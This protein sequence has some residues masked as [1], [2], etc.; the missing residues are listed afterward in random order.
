MD[1]ADKELV[2]EF[3]VESQEGLANVEA[4]ML[5]IEAQGAN[6]DTD[7]VNSVFRTM[8]SIKGAAGF[9]GL[10]RI[11]TL[12]HGLEE[13]L[14]NLRNREMIPTTE[15]ISTILRA[16]DFMKGLIDEVE[17]SNEADVAPFVAELQ[18]FRPG[19]VAVPE[20]PVVPIST[21][22]T[23][24]RKV[25]S[26]G[27]PVVSPTAPDASVPTR[28]SV[29]EEGDPS[30]ALSSAAINVPLSDTV[31]EFLIECD[32][33]LDQM[34][35]DLMQLEQDP[36]A[37]QL[38]R[39]IFRT[40]H[41]IKGGA[42]FLGL[43]E[44]EHLAHVAEDLLGKVRSG[45]RTFNRTICNAL[46]ATSDKCREGLAMVEST[47]NTS[48]LSPD[49]VIEML[50]QA[51]QA[52][53]ETVATPSSDTVEAPSAPV[54]GAAPET[55]A[56]APV[57]SHKPGA[58]AAQP[59]KPV[60]AAETPGATSA[61]TTNSGDRSNVPAGESTI[62]VDVE[63]LDKLM[64]R[65]GELVLARNQILQYTS[66]QKD[67]NFASTA[68]RLNLIT[69]ELQESVMKTRMQPIGNVWSKFPRVVRDLSAQL[70]KQV[71]IEMEGKETELDKTIIE[72]IKD[73]LTHLVR[74]SVDHGVE[75]PEVR[76]AAG[77]LAEGCLT[78]RAYHE[79]GQ[80]N[81]EISDDGAGLNFER[82]RKKA[83]ER[84]LVTPEAAARMSEREASNLI[85]LP[86]FSTAEK[87]TPVSGRGVGMDVVKTNIE[88][89][90]GTLDLQ[91][92]MGEGTTVK[93]KIP[94][95]LA[96]I[97]ALVVT[98]GG[99]RY[100]I[101]QVS[102]LELVRLEG[103]HARKRI[104]NI[105]GAP[106]YRLRGQLLPL[107]YLREVLNSTSTNG[108]SPAAGHA[109][110]P[111]GA[112]NLDFVVAK[113]KHLAW[114]TR[115]RN[116]LK[117]DESLTFDEAVSFRSCAL[118]KWLYSEGMRDYGHFAA[119]QR[120]EKLH[121]EMH[122]AVGSVIQ[123]REKGDVAKAETGLQAVDELS[124]EVVKLLNELE[125]SVVGTKATNIV[126]LRAEDRQFGLVV[127]SINDTEEIVVKPLS[128]QL[129]G[130]AAYAGATIMGDGKVA[131]ILDV[132]GAAQK[133]HV[134]AEHR[135]R[136]ITDTEKASNDDTKNRQTML[137]LAVGDR[138][139]A[140]PI[141]LVARLE[142][143]PRENIEKS[144]HHE[145]VQYRGHIMPLVR[146][147]DVLGIPSNDDPTQPLQIVVY[148]E[149]EHSLG[150]VVDRVADITDA[151]I[152]VTR[153]SVCEELLASAVIQQR[154][155]DLLNLPKII[156]RVAPKLFDLR[157]G[158][159]HLAV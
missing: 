9:L 159:H 141:S 146:L 40:M 119:V 39:N 59:T 99:D 43:A 69:T 140:M 157:K 124:G 74:N 136:A 96:I 17:K 155:T 46:L 127:D 114:K 151:E 16:S 77:K 108:E 36:N 126:V 35:R 79:G 61:S 93:I 101:P 97:P 102:L 123:L 19:V 65:V 87:V 12:A 26:M 149:G 118:G 32:E 88:R 104:E 15:L 47:G 18:R 154:V 158:D 33:N 83:V 135:D 29:P 106:V 45:E 56:S 48:A 21:G 6:V 122:N 150:F 115:L 156:R 138:Q 91:S 22:A 144:A 30:A 28:V 131:L 2:A 4:Q 95:T 147:A 100:A 41:T 42:G 3:V 107:V 60:A 139:I 116:Y 31:R 72:S 62:R 111:S 13:I 132:M 121:S 80:V 117:G 143:I 7:L 52:G 64:T 109:T 85:L 49:V 75:A 81:I 23:D 129:K 38:V 103:E 152:T 86:G 58:L 70:G 153:E 34:D 20:E 133:A 51:D 44:L 148:S 137:L 128:K 120:L 105:H 94:L 92:R 53:I 8:H 82:I 27:S 54:K 142:E 112:L 78:L 98:C 84:G 25:Q 66:K 113:G 11:G 134:V 67:S 125:H 10:D 5:S 89:I 1:I 130:I 37:N 145:V 110:A 90:G 57:A 50:W 24:G 73:P 55:R 68:Q 71:R 14:N 63:L 76:L